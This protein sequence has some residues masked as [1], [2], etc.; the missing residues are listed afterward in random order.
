ML[1]IVTAANSRYFEFLKQLLKNIIKLSNQY[2]MN[3][4]VYDL[5]MNKDQLNELKTFSHICLEY[6]AFDKYPKHVDLKT[7][8]GL[9]C[10]YAWK[11]IIIYDVCEKYGGLVYWMDTRNLCKDFTKL[12]DILKTE[13]IYTPTSS[14][15]IKQWTYPTTLQYMEGY[16]YQNFSPRNGA[17][18][19]VNYNIDWVK[20]FIKKWKDLALIDTCI[21]PEGSDRNNHRQDQAV[22]SILYYQYKDIYN[23]KLINHY[24]DVTIHNRLFSV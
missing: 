22:L 16:K 8:F 6:F 13:Y 7:N 18:V 5:G 24:I 10:T 3:I 15:T 9:H 23:F 11:P 2:E 1:T 12:I 21:C 20:D 4:I 14:G 19:G 17:V